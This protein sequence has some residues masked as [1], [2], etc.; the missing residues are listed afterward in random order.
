MS[1]I[2]VASFAYKSSSVITDQ[3]WIRPENQIA[4]AV[5]TPSQST[6]SV[7]AAT[8]EGCER[9]HGVAREVT[10]G[11][12]VAY[13]SS[14]KSNRATRRPSTTRQPVTRHSGV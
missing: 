13:R 3:S 6:M 2:E 7:A 10:R 1:A 9:I 8:A 14:T 4:I 11:T 12:V 5:L